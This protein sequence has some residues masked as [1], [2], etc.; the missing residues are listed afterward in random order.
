MQSDHKPTALVTGSSRGIGA[1]IALHLGSLNYNVVINYCKNHDAA[2]EIESAFHDPKH[3]CLIVRADITRPEDRLHLMHQTVDR[4]GTIDLLVNN[5]GITSP[6]REDLL[7]SSE[8]SW[9]QVLGTNLKGPFFL[10][11]LAAKQMMTNPVKN[12][13]RGTIINISSISAFAVSQNR[14]DYCIAKRGMQ[15]MTKLFASRLASDAIRVYEICPGIIK[16]DMTAPVTD[17]Y[18]ALLKSGMA[19]IARWGSG[20][21]VARAVALLAGG[22]LPYS[23]GERLHVDGGFHIRTI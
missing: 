15:M 20:H 6:G 22:E 23:T 12:D 19:P 14:G 1:A 2:L 7:D 5:A 13:L 4:F 10:S 3:S 11:Q 9:D 21:D 18:D 8:S 17:K 16:S